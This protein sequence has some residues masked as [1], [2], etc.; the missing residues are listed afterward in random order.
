[1]KWTRSDYLNFS[2]ALSSIKRIIGRNIIFKPRAVL[3]KSGKPVSLKQFRSVVNSSERV[4]LREKFSHEYYE[5]TPKE[6][7]LLRAAKKD[8][9]ENMKALLGN[10]WK[11]LS[12][13]MNIYNVP[14]DS[15]LVTEIQKQL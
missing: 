11:K 4:V 1:M 9:S 12:N 7:A 3:D 5:K 2:Q 6:R 10:N 8:Y 15:K 14:D 13:S